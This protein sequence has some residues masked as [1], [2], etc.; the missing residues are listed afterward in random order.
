MASVVVV[1]NRFCGY[2]HT[3]SLYHTTTGGFWYGDRDR[4]HIAG[5]TRRAKKDASPPSPLIFPKRANAT[6]PV[7]NV[8][9]GMLQVE[10]IVDVTSGVTESDF[11]DR[12]LTCL[13]ALPRFGEH[14][15]QFTTV[16]SEIPF[17]GAQ[18]GNTGRALPFFPGEDAPSAATRLTQLLERVADLIQSGAAEIFPPSAT[19]FPAHAGDLEG[20]S[21]DTEDPLHKAVRHGGEP[22]DVLGGKSKMAEKLGVPEVIEVGEGGA[23]RG[24]RTREGTSRVGDCDGS[25]PMLYSLVQWQLGDRTLKP[26]FNISWYGAVPKIC[27]IRVRA[28]LLSPM[29]DLQPKFQIGN[30]AFRAAVRLAHGLTT[31]PTVGKPEYPKLTCI[32]IVKGATSTGKSWHYGLVKH[33]PPTGT[34][35]DRRKNDRKH[36]TLDPTARNIPFTGK[37]YGI[38][39]SKPAKLSIIDNCKRKTRLGGVLTVRNGF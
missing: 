5:N 32:K 34:G 13:A 11:A 10:R 4:R 23:G 31:T 8:E 18:F 3:V 6:I 35:N 20:A 21:N 9:W 24:M 37:T 36:K 16:P 28:P 1:D 7:A 17:P 19:P 2:V 22:D 27:Y 25:G 39:R 15:A 33:P 29:C 12:V 30:F 14:K 26:P 38:T